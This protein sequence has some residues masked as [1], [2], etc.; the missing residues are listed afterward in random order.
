MNHLATIIDKLE[1]AGL[2]KDVVFQ[3]NTLLAPVSPLFPLTN[4]V[5]LLEVSTADFT[6]EVDELEETF[7]DAMATL[8]RS[9]ATRQKIEKAVT[10]LKLAAEHFAKD[11]N[12]IEAIRSGW[13]DTVIKVVKGLINEVKGNPTKCLARTFKCRECDS[14][15]EHDI[16]CSVCGSMI[17]PCL[18]NAMSN[19]RCEHHKGNDINEK[20]DVTLAMQRQMLVKSDSRRRTL[21][22]IHNSPDLLE[23]TADIEILELRQQE[24]FESLGELDLYELRQAMQKK[25]KVL[26]K[27]IENGGN[28]EAVAML[29]DIV[30][31]AHNDDKVWG[32]ISTNAEQLSKLRERE[33]KRIIQASEI[34][35]KEAF[36]ANLI[37][38]RDA[39]L[40][41]IGSV[42]LQLPKMIVDGMIQSLDPEDY[43]SQKLPALLA[44]NADN[45]IE[46]AIREAVFKELSGVR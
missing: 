29:Q 14:R 15:Q 21:D 22:K 20:A 16:V 36:E 35:T 45:R 12:H 38:F 33:H 1:V 32:M 9:D 31:N 7:H 19:G 28:E 18:G 17:R 27:T 44:S 5:R 4:L 26:Q 43:I 6:K 3:I 2:H 13:Y 10:W 8:P 42:S 30:F 24:L 37:K 11:N 25:L 39:V 34:V 23:N 41:G 40:R 46:K